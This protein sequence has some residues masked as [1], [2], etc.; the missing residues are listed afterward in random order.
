M[1]KGLAEML[2]R[3]I[4]FSSYWFRTQSLLHSSMDLTLTRIIRGKENCI[5]M[6]K[7]FERMSSIFLEARLA[8][9]DEGMTD[10]ELRQVLCVLWHMLLMPREQVC[11]RSWEEV[12]KMRRVIAACQNHYKSMPPQEG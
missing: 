9:S 11:A 3:A 12:S 10:Q 5:L 8:L 7:S 2:G 6:Y 1:F 4:S